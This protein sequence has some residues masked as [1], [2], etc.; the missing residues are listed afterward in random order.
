MFQTLDYRRQWEDAGP[1]TLNSRPHR[2][3]PRSVKEA[4]RSLRRTRLPVKVVI[5][6]LICIC[7]VLVLFQID[8]H[9]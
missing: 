1:G 4:S 6:Q 3:A 2:S 7:P 5:F 9:C 8:H